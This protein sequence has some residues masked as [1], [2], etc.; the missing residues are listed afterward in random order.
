MRRL[1][2]LITILLLGPLVSCTDTSKKTLG[3][4]NDYEVSCNRKKGLADYVDDA[5]SVYDFSA[6]QPFFSVIHTNVKKDWKINEVSH[7]KKVFEFDKSRVIVINNIIV[8]SIILNDQILVNNGIHT[9]MTYQNVEG[10]FLDIKDSSYANDV[11]VSTGRSSILIRCCGQHE[12]EWEFLFKND[13][14]RKMIFTN[15]SSLE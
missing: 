5:V 6:S 2:Q 8:K 4:N 11:F 10:M 14:L 15:I 1:F 3:K 9:G 13:T 12:N 7:R